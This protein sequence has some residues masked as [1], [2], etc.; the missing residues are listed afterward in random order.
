[1]GR[2]VRTSRPA[3]LPPLLPNPG[4]RSRAA[5]CIWTR[6]LAAAG[7]WGPV[8]GPL[9]SGPRGRRTWPGWYAGVSW[10]E[11]YQETASTMCGGRVSPS[12]NPADAV[13]LA[14]YH[15]IW[16]SA[17]DLT[18]GSRP[19]A[20]STRPASA[21]RRLYDRQLTAAPTRPHSASATCNDSAS[22]LLGPD[23][24]TP[25]PPHIGTRRMRPRPRPSGPNGA[26]TSD[27]SRP[28][29]VPAYASDF[30][31][32][33]GRRDGRRSR[34]NRH[35]AIQCVPTRPCRAGSCFRRRRVTVL[36][37]GG[38]QCRSTI[39]PDGFCP[40]TV[41]MIDCTPGAAHSLRIDGS[42]RSRSSPRPAAREARPAG[43][44]LA[45]P[46][47]HGNSEWRGAG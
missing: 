26:K 42:S 13:E 17:S 3:G 39:A 34:G 7:V 31:T 11:P 24:D 21:A 41:A 2:S 23:R 22:C 35:R 20:S 40:A 1:V 18:V 27:W 19:R 47:G 10:Q 37:P 30:L 14:G 44:K 29:D 8:A 12:R 32:V 45:P 6:P 28:L 9:W 43:E 38:R 5:A 16:L 36:G 4:G 15:P 33:Y 25:Q 46:P